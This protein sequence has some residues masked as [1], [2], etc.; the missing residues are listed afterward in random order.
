MIGI[1]YLKYFP[2]EVFYLPS[3]L[4]IFE[5]VFLNPDGSR[6]IVG[7]P[8]PVFTA[9]E[10]QYGNFASKTYLSEQMT[11]VNQGYHI[12]PDTSLLNM[13][14]DKDLQKDSLSCGSKILKCQKFFENVENTGTEVN[15]RCVNCRN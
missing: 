6:E 14:P 8:H 10:H 1:K 5:S 13:K 3:G 7:G 4:T 2:R 15:Y 12:N 9:I 11:L